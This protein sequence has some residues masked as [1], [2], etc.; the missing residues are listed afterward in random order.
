MNEMMIECWM[1]LYGLMADSL[2]WEILD[3][4]A[5]DL[6]MDSGVDLWSIIAQNILL[7]LVSRIHGSSR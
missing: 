6:N 3:A 2:V 4:Q 5:R 7:I 1:G